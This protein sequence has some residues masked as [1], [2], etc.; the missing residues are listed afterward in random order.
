[1]TNNS[2][3]QISTPA[4]NS[5]DA[6]IS[7]YLDPSAPQSFFLFAGAGSGKTRTLVNALNYVRDTHGSSLMRHGHQVGVITY[8][9]AAVDE[10]KRR[11]DFH[12]LFHV[13]TIHSF[14]WDVIQGFD[15]DIRTWL[16]NTLLEQ[17]DELNE[18]ERKGR[19]GKASRN[20]QAQIESKSR[21]LERLDSIKSFVY[22][23]NGE[24]N[25]PNSLN[26]TEVISLCAEFVSQKPLMAR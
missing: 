12:P 14:A 4:N 24:N 11:I 25:E 17:L 1:M 7:E 20:R 8:T 22:N 21:R 16:N 26:H 19:A 15:Q 3:P 6:Q 2:Y 18:K 5:V 13:S 9:N 23:P 10:I